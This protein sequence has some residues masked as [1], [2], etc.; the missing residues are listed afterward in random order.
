MY[1][2]RIVVG[3]AVLSQQRQGGGVATGP[4]P[5]LPKERTVVSS[6]VVVFNRPSTLMVGLVVGTVGRG[7]ICGTKEAWP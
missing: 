5:Q 3:E 7:E 6:Q 1:L 4:S 2:K